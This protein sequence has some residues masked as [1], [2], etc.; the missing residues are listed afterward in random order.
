[1]LHGG[2]RDERFESKSCNSLQAGNVY[3]AQR[4][5]NVLKNSKFLHTF[6]ARAFKLKKGLFKSFSGT[7]SFMGHPNVVAIIP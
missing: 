7:K 4:H 5:F 6:C 1:M 2:P 3:C